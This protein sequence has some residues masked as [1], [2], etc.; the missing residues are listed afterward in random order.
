MLRARS[1]PASVFISKL[2]LKTPHQKPCSFHSTDCTQ[3]ILDVRLLLNVA[4]R[5]QQAVALVIAC[6]IPSLYGFGLNLY[7][8][9]R[10][11]SVVIRTIHSD[12]TCIQ[13]DRCSCTDTVS[14]LYMHANSHNKDSVREKRRNVTRRS[15]ATLFYNLYSEMTAVFGESPCS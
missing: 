10:R 3:H 6:Y 11:I 15:R 8:W 14:S 2:P 7:L 13:A 1:Q 9:R 5:S 12:E 4:S